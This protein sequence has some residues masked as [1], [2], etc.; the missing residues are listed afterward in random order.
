MQALFQ[1]SSTVELPRFLRIRKALQS[2]RRL[3]E[4]DMAFMREACQAA[5]EQ[6]PLADRRQ[7][8]REFYARKIMLLHEITSMALANEKNLQ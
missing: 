3:A 4:E 5:A 2:G 6:K 7:E 1:Q 8:Y